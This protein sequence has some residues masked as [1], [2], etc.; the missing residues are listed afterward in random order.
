MKYVVLMVVF[1]I[2]LI[3]DFYIVQQLE[4]VI[5]WNRIKKYR[6]DIIEQRIDRIEKEL[7]HDSSK[8]QPRSKR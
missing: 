4:Y 8:I 7:I 1:L 3:L 2:T 5:I 6:V